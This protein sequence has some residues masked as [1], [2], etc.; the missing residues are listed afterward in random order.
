[1]R[2]RAAFFSAMDGLFDEE[3]QAF[4]ASFRRFLDREVVPGYTGWRDR[5]GVPREVFR[6]AGEYGFLG[7]AVPAEFGGGGVADPLFGAVLAEETMRA[8]LTGFGLALLTHVAVCVPWVLATADAAQRAA[9]LPGL[10]CGEYLAAVLG[11]DEPLAARPVGHGLSVTGSASDVVNAAAADLL[12]TVV[13]TG[14]EPDDVRVAVLTADTVVLDPGA[15]PLGGQGASVAD[16]RLDGVAVPAS[17]LMAGDGTEQAGHLR[18]DRNLWLAALS[19]SGEFENTRRTLSDAAAELAVVRVFLDACLR[20]RGEGPLPADRAA[21]AVLRA[22][23]LHARVVDQ[24]LQL[25]GGYGYMREYPI[26]QAYADARYLRL[27]ASAGP[28][29]QE[30]VAVALGL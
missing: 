28:A 7:M 10:A 12:V 8:G 30:A 21:A 19:V 1:M 22:G 4:R 9:W 13:R 11:L 3:H 15:A 26:A 29:N 18:A 20:G 24:G 5:G 27:Q 17:G 25:H 16:V 6:I 23:A 14:D 2:R